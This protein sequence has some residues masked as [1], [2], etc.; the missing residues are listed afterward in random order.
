MKKVAIIF[1]LILILLLTACSQ[2]VTQD[3]SVTSSAAQKNS[4]VKNPPQNVITL[5][6]SE[7]LIGKYAVDNDPESY[8]E[9]RSDG[10][11]Q[12]SLNALDGY[13]KYDSKTVTAYLYYSEERT[14]I[15][16]CLT[17]GSNTMVGG[18]LSLNFCSTGEENNKEFILM[19][20]G[21]DEP[22]RFVKVN[23]TPTLKGEILTAYKNVLQNKV[24]INLKDVVDEKNIT[25]NIF[26][27]KFFE[28]L[29][30][31]DATFSSFHFSII[32][33][34]KDS[35]PEV[36][37][38][39]IVGDD[40]DNQPYG[41]VVLHYYKGNVY[42]YL[43]SYKGLEELKKD[44]TFRWSGGAG[45]WGYSSLKFNNDTFKQENFTYIQSGENKDGN[46]THLYFVDNMPST[47]DAFISS[48]DKQGT[49]KSVDWY[50]FTPI[51]IENYF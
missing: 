17:S 22:E 9:I 25:Q 36:I 3:G 51:N 19:E 10:T 13:A 7:D 31:D 43:F 5:E 26:L 11:I 1:I 47:E 49:K 28:S 16:F 48:V 37:V 38:D 33:M 39:I 44:G 40:K 4:I 41:Y 32:D 42:G 20:S 45:D 46:P 50:D 15:S 30:S 14:N 29:A 6:I 2:P 8:F 21:Y 12:L 18:Y 34:D 24:P 23:Q 27:N 35:T